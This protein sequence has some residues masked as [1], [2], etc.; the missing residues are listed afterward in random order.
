MTELSLYPVREDF[1]AEVGDLDLSVPQD[2]ATTAAI[3]AA[4][5]RYAVLI[6]PDQRLDEAQQ[7]A[8]AA[9]FG[10]IEPPFG[11]KLGTHGRLAPALVDVSNLSKDNN[12]WREEDRLRLL[13]EGDKLWHTDSSFN[14]LPALASI[15][16]AKSIVPV[17]GLTEFAD[18]RAAWDDLPA[19]M[20]ARLDGLIAEHSWFVSRKRYGVEDF[21]DEMRADHPPV[22]QLLVRTLPETGRKTLYLALHIGRILGLPDAEAGALVDELVAH[23]T[24]PEYVH[25][26][27]WRV[28][29]VVMW[30][31]RCTM[32][33][34][35]DYDDLRWPRDYKRATISDVANTLVQ[36]GVAIPEAYREVAA[37]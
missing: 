35:T 33:H 25:R 23:A 10:P 29:D 24:R 8:F 12:I 17:G 15:L 31:N 21:S 14:F 6:F 37:A 20:K 36:E 32:H 27:R 30:D 1:V 3:R 22:P 34:V 28:G 16:H 19:A 7:L 13:R 11:A 9:S 2:A 18:E 5:S 4:L 26:H